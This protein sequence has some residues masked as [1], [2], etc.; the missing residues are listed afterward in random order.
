M[1][2]HA[3]GTLEPAVL[4]HTEVPAAVGSE[5]VE[6]VL[7]R[8]DVSTDGPGADTLTLRVLVGE[9]SVSWQLPIAPFVA[10]LP[11]QLGDDGR[12]VLL[13]VVE[14][15][16]ESGFWARPVDCADLVA[17]LALPVAD[18]A[19]ALQ[20]RLISWLSADLEEL[21]HVDAHD[22]ATA[23][24]PAQT[25][26]DAV[27]AHYRGELS[28]SQEA[29]RVIRALQLLEPGEAVEVG[30][31]LAAALSQGVIGASEHHRELVRSGL[32]PFETESLRLLAELPD[33]LAATPETDRTD[34]T[35]HALLAVPDRDEGI[36]A[37]VSLTAALARAT[38]GPDLEPSA[39]LAH[40]AMVD[41]AGLA[42]LARLWVSLGVFA[43]SPPAED[44]DNALALVQMI[45]REGAPADEWLR[46][47]SDVLTALARD[48]AGRKRDRLAAALEAVERLHTEP[49]GPQAAAGVQACLTLARYLRQRAGLGP[50]SW[51]IGRMA[52]AAQAA[53]EA[54]ARA[55][56]KIDPDIVV[57]L[58]LELLDGD[59]QG[60]DL[61]DGFLCAAAMLLA[62]VD[63][64]ADPVLRQAQ[65]A[66]ML[67]RL[68]GG[69]KGSRWML[70]LLLRES[71]G[72]DPLSADLRPVMPPMPADD[73]DRVA[74]RAGRLGVTR[75]GLS[76]LLV[77]A[78]SL[79]QEARR[80]PDDVLGRLLAAG[81]ENHELLRLRD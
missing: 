48:V 69:A 33:L 17:E 43:Q 2:A 71:P 68:P 36:R 72:H 76:S 11:G 63:P 54:Y 73:P 21:L 1:H 67:E 16:P 61:V 39:L 29:T 26:A 46:A 23:V 80:T 74:Q 70:D 24:S 8:V 15:A 65:V 38:A 81:L 66:E 59:V 32:G 34:V 40:L 57:D 13:G 25:V 37:A 56:G 30:I 51:V 47:T 41:D 12:M 20:G 55:D 78:Q 5:L 50:G 27:Q 3:D 7:P 75:A 9:H 53:G 28:A 31:R 6:A 4:L 79:G 60:A 19:E 77:M 14:G 49:S 44:P 10:A 35:M 52:T 58:L 22:R 62:D 42:R 18:L 64:G 45:A